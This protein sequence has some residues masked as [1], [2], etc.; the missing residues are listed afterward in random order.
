MA[1]DEAVHGGMEG[2]G[3]LAP[4]HHSDHASRVETPL[5]LVEAVRTFSGT[6]EKEKA[7]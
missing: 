4:E 5:I 3:A 2:M 1:H 6:P 7:A